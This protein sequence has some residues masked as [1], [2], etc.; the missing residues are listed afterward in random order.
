M[1]RVADTPLV[2]SLWTDLAP[3]GTLTL[4]IIGRLDAH[5][6]AQIW[7]EA[8]EA[9]GK[10]PP[11][12]IIIDASKMDYCDGAGIGF[13]VELL[14]RQHDAGGEIEIRELAEESQ[15]LLSM[16]NL[17]DFYKKDKEL[18]DPDPIPEE[19]GRMTVQLLRDIRELIVFIGQMTVA[20]PLAAVNWRLLRWK[21]TASVAET[22]GVNALP[23]VSL[24]GFLMGLIMAFQSAIPM[25]RFGA[26]IFVADLI[27]ISMLKEL[28]PLLTAIVLA[29]RSGSAFA[30]EIGTMKVN[31]EVNALTTMGLDPVR[32]LVIPRVVA[33]TLMTPLLSIFASLF[34]LIGGAIVILS[35]NYTLTTYIN[36]VI[37]SVDLFAFLSGLFKATVFGLLVSGIG[38][39]RGLQ[40]KTGASAVGASTTSAVVSGIII[41]AVTDGIFSVLFYYLEVWRR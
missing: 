25:K 28:G 14:S 18:P 6:T 3:N 35:L 12:R 30:A 41:V 16:F 1:V 5:S 38:C 13:L 10:V 17:E 36:R 11:Q 27:A 2:T 4:S 40:T 23:I 15:R 37:A 33:A 7:K 21:D 19:L 9:I 31:E 26:E 20:I 32:F 22:A 24:I 29:G 39:L 34:G 8:F